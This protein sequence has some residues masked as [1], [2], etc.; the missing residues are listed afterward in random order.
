MDSRLA[1]PRE[2]ARHRFREQ[3]GLAFEAVHLPRMAGRVLGALLLG[4]AGGMN[5]GDLAA[6]LDAS[7]ASISSSTRLLVHYGFVER[8]VPDDDRRDRFV[9]DEDAWTRVLEERFAFLRSLRDLA[10][11]GLPLIDPDGDPGRLAEARDLYGFLEEELPAL[12]G[13]WQE[14]RPRPQEGGAR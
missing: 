4:P 2:R 14:R 1:V 3:V 5:A 6:A 13:R 7:K 12:V 9:V 11:E 10:D 8:T